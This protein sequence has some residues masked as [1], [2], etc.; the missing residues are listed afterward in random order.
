M[1]YSSESFL[2]YCLALMNIEGVGSIIARKISQKYENLSELFQSKSSGEFQCEGVP[3]VVFDRIR[4]FTDFDLIEKE[5]RFINDNNIH[6]TTFFNEKYPSN[7]KECYDA[8]FLLFSKGNVDFTNDRIISLVGT[9]NV[10]SYGIGF[11]K[12]LMQEIATY[13]PIIVSGYAYGV[14]IQAHLAAIENDLKTFAVLGHGL[15]QTYPKI[16]KKYNNLI[17]EHGGFISEFA[18]YDVFKKEN[19]IKRNRIV[20]GLSKATLV[21]ESAIKGG[22]LSTAKFANDYNRDVFALPGRN[23]DLYSAGCNFLIKTNQANLLTNVDDLVYYLNWDVEKKEMQNMKSFV[24]SD[25][26]TKEE[27]LVVNFLKDNGAEILDVIA[28]QTEVP[29][30]KLSA[31]LLNLE[32]RNLINPLPGKLFELKK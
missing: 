22:S 24:L 28:L 14:D 32:L 6:V 5:I 18:S 9:R 25:D 17:L 8:P 26:L 21:I 27:L 19:F 20:A 2:K 30:Y 13:N 10:T 7:L 4:N 23:S 12:E 15:D 3:K 11:I 29:V 16:H 1:N 31:I